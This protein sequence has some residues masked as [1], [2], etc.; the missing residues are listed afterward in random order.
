MAP[1]IRRP[2]AFNLSRVPHCAI[3]RRLFPAAV[4]VEILISN[5]SWGQVASRDETRFAIIALRAPVI[6]LVGLRRDFC[7]VRQLVRPGKGDTVAR[8]KGQSLPSAGYLRLALPHYDETHIPVRV[9]AEA[10]DAI[11]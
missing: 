1:V 2:A 8:S 9:D 7:V 4:V 6:E 10:V 11:A 3:A 5:Y